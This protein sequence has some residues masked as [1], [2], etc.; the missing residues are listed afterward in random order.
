MDSAGK[1]S[2]AVATKIVDTNARIFYGL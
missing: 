1:F 2:P